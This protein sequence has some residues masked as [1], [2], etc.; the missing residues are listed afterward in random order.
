VLLFASLMVLSACP[1]TVVVTG[2]A[3]DASLLANVLNSHG[4]STD[5]STRCPSTEVDV[6]RDGDSFVVRTA[7]VERGVS[8][9]ETAAVVVESWV[10]S[11]VTAP[12]WV[13]PVVQAAPV[14]PVPVVAPTPS[15]RAVRLAVRAEGGV[16]SD[17]STWPSL[18]LQGCAHV[19][20]VCLGGLLRASMDSSLTGASSKFDTG[21][22]ALDGFVLGEWAFDVGAMTLSPGVG[23]GIGW[24]QSRNAPVWARAVEP[25]I[26]AYDV[27]MKALAQ[28]TTRFA[29][30]S[31]PQVEVTLGADI[32]LLANSAAIREEGI[33][34]AGEPLAFLR[35]GAGI[36][37]AP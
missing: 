32:A 16:G 5:A 36:G 23:V 19:G 9:I 13:L 15:P 17:G 22:V 12:L 31:G 2:A 28:M 26:E 6:T 18:V 24:L 29:L 3:D 34:I 21:R 35:V 4:I 30:T 25:H 27:D 10:R 20:P 8:D 33:V 7:D 37:F 14:T 11:D 1:P